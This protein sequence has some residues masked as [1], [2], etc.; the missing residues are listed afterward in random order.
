MRAGI[1]CWGVAALSVCMGLAVPAASADQFPLPKGAKG[2]SQ[3]VDMVMGKQ[4]M[5]TSMFAASQSPDELRAFYETSLRKQGW[6]V[7]PVPWM[8]RV[9]ERLDAVRKAAAEQPETIGQDPNAQYA[10]TVAYQQIEERIRSSLYATR[11]GEGLLVTFMPRQ[12]QTMIM[13]ARWRLGSKANPFME[14]TPESLPT[15]QIPSPTGDALPKNPCCS[16][17]AVPQELRKLPHSIPLYPNARPLISG[18]VPK[19]VSS[20]DIV[21]EFYVTSDTPE[22]VLA[23]F[24]EQMAYNGWAADRE[25]PVP[26]QSL[27][28][29]P[30]LSGMQMTMRARVYRR[31]D[32]NEMCALGLTGGTPPS[33]STD[34]T[35]KTIITVHYFKRPVVQQ[36]PNVPILP[37]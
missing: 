13:V 23:Y 6:T 27:P 4:P 30:G 19:N 35:S 14:L 17:E 26:S 3:P 22:Q 5:Q 20:Q 24:D 10:G 28:Q 1:G 7:G 25:V 37:K 15:D 8:A 31:A 16:G 9:K 34:R 21:G 29:V 18:A 36:A 11:S 2:M 33:M 12:R 32:T